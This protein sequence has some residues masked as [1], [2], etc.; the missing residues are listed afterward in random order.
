MERLVVT[1]RE[2]IRATL[3]EIARDLQH[4]D[5]RRVV[6]HI[7]SGQPELKRKAE[8]EL[9]NY[10]F[11]ECR[12]TRIH[13]IDV[14]T[15]ASPHSAVAEFNIIATGSF[16]EGGYEFTDTIP[17]WIR[18]HLVREKDGRWGVQDYEHD[19]P[20]RMIMQTPGEAK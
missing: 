11:S 18:L 19:D 16:K 17:R 9:P 6:S 1:D 20:Q 13:S 7:Y 10:R 5:H 8:A 3:L 2:A 12:I 15:S 4:N 14:D